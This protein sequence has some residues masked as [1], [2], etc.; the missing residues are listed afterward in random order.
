MCRALISSNVPADIEESDRNV[1][2]RLEMLEDYAESCRIIHMSS[3]S[4]A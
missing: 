1:R 4:A 3:L 2:G